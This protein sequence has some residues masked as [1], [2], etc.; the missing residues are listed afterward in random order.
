MIQLTDNTKLSKKEE[1]NID[2]S[3]LLRWGNKIITGD[4]GREEPG[5]ERNGGGKK[6]GQQDQV[7][8]ETSPG[9]QENE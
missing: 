1:E 3:I 8:E 7:W 6:W 9:G 2:A 4:G 5:R